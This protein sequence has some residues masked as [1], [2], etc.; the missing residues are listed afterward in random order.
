MMKLFVHNPV[1]S[2]NYFKSKM[3]L[4]PGVVAQP[5]IIELGRLRQWDLCK[6]EIILVYRVSSRIAQA[7]QWDPVSKTNKQASLCPPHPIPPPSFLPLLFLSS[8]LLPSSFSRFP[9]LFLPFLPFLPLYPSSPISR[10][11]L[12]IG[13]VFE[14]CL[15]SSLFLSSTMAF[16]A[17][18]VFFAELSWTSQA[19]IKLPWTFPIRITKN[20]QYFKKPKFASKNACEMYFNTHNQPWERADNVDPHSCPLLRLIAA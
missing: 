19:V 16:P 12:Q 3:H 14:V 5:L 18:E 4:W 11:S 15:T 10:L 9:S 7:T 6:F 13:R 8:P 20:V 1:V 17:G 2:C